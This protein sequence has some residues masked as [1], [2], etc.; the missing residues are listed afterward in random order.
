LILWFHSP[1]QG[2]NQQRRHPKF[3]NP[4]WNN[5]ILL[6]LLHLLHHLLL[7]LANYKPP[8]I[9]VLQQYCLLPIGNILVLFNMLLIFSSLLRHSDLALMLSIQH[10]NLGLG[11]HSQVQKE[12]RRRLK[13]DCRDSI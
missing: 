1:Q 9:D 11:Y 3:P 5:W 8:I 4:R 10:L 2:P 12:R 6:L 13:L 7:Q